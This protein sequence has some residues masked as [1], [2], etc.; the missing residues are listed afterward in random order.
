MIFPRWT[1]ITSPLGRWLLVLVL[2]AGLG[3]SAYLKGRMD[4]AA[5]SQAE[6]LQSE[7]ETLRHQIKTINELLESARERETAAAEQA[8]KLEGKVSEYET[9]LAS[10]PIPRSCGLTRNDIERLRNIASGATR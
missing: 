8:S 2:A 3:A 9:K 5:I 4:C 6:A 10:V 7:V 1:F